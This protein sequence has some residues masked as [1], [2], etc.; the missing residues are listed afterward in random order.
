M[1][2]ED[3]RDQYA[4]RQLK[5]PRGRHTGSLRPNG[6]IDAAVA[7]YWKRNAE[8]RR[9]GP[10]Y[11]QQDSVIATVAKDMQVSESS[12]RW[13]IKRSKKRSN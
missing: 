4:A 1:I 13:A 8:V 3:L 9:V 11:G 6:K 10:F 12:L 5:L 7:E 2:H